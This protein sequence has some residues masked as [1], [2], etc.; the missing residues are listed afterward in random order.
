MTKTEKC[1]TYH[2]HGNLDLDL[3]EQTKIL[4]NGFLCG[5]KEKHFW[6]VLLC[7][8]MQLLFSVYI[9]M[10]YSCELFCSVSLY[11][12]YISNGTRRICHAAHWPVAT[13]RYAVPFGRPI[14]RYFHV[15]HLCLYHAL[16][17]H[18]K[19]FSIMELT[20]DHGILSVIISVLHCCDFVGFC[21][22]SATQL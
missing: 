17:S 6:G 9:C 18:R 3:Y 22:F 19:W 14:S 16:V 5:N 15:C 20:I 13:N 11:F 21:Y 7:C 8:V 2:G 1:E 10:I 4:E 12:V